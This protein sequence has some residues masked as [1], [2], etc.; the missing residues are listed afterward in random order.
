MMRIKSNW[1]TGRAPRGQVRVFYSLVALLLL[2]SLLA[3][4]NGPFP[5]RRPAPSP[6]ALPAPTTLPT[7]VPSEQPSPAATEQPSPTGQPLPSPTGP[8]VPT[9]LPSPTPSDL[10][11]AAPDFVVYP[12]PRLYSGDEVTFDVIPRNLG[13]INPN[14]LVVHIYRYTDGKNEIIA[15]GRV[16]YPTFEPVPRARLMWTWDT[17]G[18]TGPQ[19]LVA[20]LDPDDQIQQG[21][22]NPGNNIVTMTVSILPAGQLPEPEAGAIWST[23]TVSCCTI[24][25]LSGTSADRDLVT[26]TNAAQAAVGDIEQRLGVTISE[27]MNMYFIARVIGQ[28]G[29]AYDGTVLSYLDR[30]YSGVNLP[31]V[32]R[33]EATH[34]MDGRLVTVYPPAI[35]REGF[36]TYMSG[37]HFKL[38][39]IPER[40]AALFELNQFVPLQQLANNFYMQQH[41]VG[42]LEGAGFISF[43]VDTRGWEAFRAFYTSFEQVPG[44]PA[45]MLEAALR[46]NF[47]WSLSEAEQAFTDW[48]KAHPPTSDQ[49]RDLKD[50]IELFDTVRRY[51]ARDD[52]SAYWMSGM[53]P[54]PRDAVNRNIVADFVRHPRAPENIA[55]ETMLIAARE[56]LF[57][58]QYGRCEELTAEVNRVLESGS[59]ATSPA[60]DYLAVV[61]AVA[62]AGYEAQQIEV[63]GDSAR[64]EAIANWPKLTV[65]TLQRTAEGWSRP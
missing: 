7:A 27:P 25:Y 51:Q 64:V 55:L 5:T 47:D 1:R 21:D 18:L 2:L 44:A 54:N 45:D 16:G 57:A 30:H 3:G 48:L 63:Q 35:M 38:E 36:A 22:A 58:G 49:V 43:I 9:P 13:S 23:T 17:T 50:T 31:I 40:T 4:C 28:G 26:I 10:Y 29:Y 12:E 19:T 56:A 33:H 59:F 46:K 65:L 52:P 39:P 37:G 60:A 53:L 8:P 41:E 61:K 11:L 15:E 6:T 62:A 20:W 42:Y 34:V 24:H 32:L 14:D